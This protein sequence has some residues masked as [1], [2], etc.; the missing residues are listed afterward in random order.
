MNCSN[1]SSKV[2]ILLLPDRNPL[3]ILTLHAWGTI[4]FSKPGYFWMHARTGASNL[5]PIAPLP[6]SRPIFCAWIWIARRRPRPAL[7]GFMGLP[8]LPPLPTIN[9]LTSQNMP[10]SLPSLSHFGCNLLLLSLPLLLPLHACQ[11]GAHTTLLIAT[12]GLMAAAT[13]SPTSV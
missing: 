12:A 5:L 9:Q 10:F 8:I 1:S 6:H 11:H 13:T 3:L 4:W 2:S 7:P